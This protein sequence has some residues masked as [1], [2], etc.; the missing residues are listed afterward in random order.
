MPGGGNPVATDQTLTCPFFE[1]VQQGG[2]WNFR[3]FRWRAVGSSRRGTHGRAIL[4]H[5]ADCRDRSGVSAA[6]MTHLIEVDR[7]KNLLRTVGDAGVGTSHA[8]SV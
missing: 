6:V 4:I 2:P 1:R 8:L 7:A 3:F 5:G